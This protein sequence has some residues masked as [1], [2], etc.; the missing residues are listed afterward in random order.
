MNAI[1]VCRKIVT[2]HQCH[3]I[4]HR[5]GTEYDAKPWGTG[6]HKGW[7]IVDAFTASAIVQVYDALNNDNK[8][9]FFALPIDK[10]AKVAFKLCR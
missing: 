6:N 10:M 5:G 9:K 8:V 1:E 4:R 3:V 7:V 2:E